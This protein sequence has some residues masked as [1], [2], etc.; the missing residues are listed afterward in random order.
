MGLNVRQVTVV[1]LLIASLWQGA[2]YADDL[3]PIR[4]ILQ[5]PDS[6]IDLGRA[7]LTIDGIIDP[8]IDVAANLKE[9]DSIVEKIKFNLSHGSSNDEKLAALRAYLYMPGEWNDYRVYSYDLAY[10]L[11]KNIHE[12]LL[13]TYMATRKGNCVS[14]PLLFVVLGQRLGLNVTAALAPMHVFVKYRNDTG[15]WINL[16]ATSGANSARDV[17]IRQQNPMTDEAIAN[18]IYM[19]PLSRRETVA[20]MALTLTEYYSEQHQFQKTI[21]VSNLVLEYSP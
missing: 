19:R 14:M 4:A 1:L 21:A 18:G 10:P 20:A 16:E 6:Q 8:D 2:A 12:K 3:T 9:I 17:W 7:K 5:L 11:G 15:E 13:P